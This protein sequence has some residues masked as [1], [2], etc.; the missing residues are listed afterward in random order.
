MT[1][2]KAVE[3]HRELWRWVSFETVKRKR[4]VYKEEYFEEIHPE[5]AGIE[6]NCFCC[7]YASQISI[8]CVACPVVWG[9]EETCD[10]SIYDDWF[11]TDNSDYLQA[12]SYARKIADLKERKTE[13]FDIVESDKL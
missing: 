3:M 12:A 5:L 8:F 11:K 2:R 9:N 4:K 1:K 13:Y 6:N 7:E 10:R